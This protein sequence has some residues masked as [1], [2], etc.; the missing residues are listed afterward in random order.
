M[1]SSQVTCDFPEL[2][3]QNSAEKSK[4]RASGSS[5]GPSQLFC[6]RDLMIPIGGI[7]NTSFGIHWDLVLFPS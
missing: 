7:S 2:I 6:C 4:G 3:I 5:V 1:S